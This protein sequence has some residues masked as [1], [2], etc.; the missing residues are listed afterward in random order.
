MGSAGGGGRTVRTAALGL[1]VLG[2]TALLRKQEERSW[3]LPDGT[4]SG[5]QYADLNRGASARPAGPVPAAP[6]VV[7]APDP[8][9]EPVAADL[10]TVEEYAPD[11]DGGVPDDEDAPSGSTATPPGGRKRRRKGKRRAA[12]A[13]R[14]NHV[15]ADATP[16]EIADLLDPPADPDDLLPED[17]IPLD[18]VEPQPRGRRSRARV[19]AARAYGMPFVRAPRVPPAR[20]A[21]RPARWRRPA[22]IAAVAA[23]VGA[24]AVLPWVVPQ[25]RDTLGASVPEQAIRTPSVADPKIEP[26]DGFVGPVGVQALN[27]PYAGVRLA[28]A[29]A[30]REVRVPRLHVSSDVLPISGR[31]GALVPPADAQELG[32]WKEGRVAGAR[33]G[34][35]VVTGHTVHTGGGA[36]DHLGELVPGDTVRVRTDHGW[37][38]YVVRRSTVY[39]TAALARNAEEILRRGGDGRLVLITCDDW[40]GHEYLSNAVVYAVPVLDEPFAGG[41]AASP[42]RGRVPDGGPE[43]PVTRRPGNTGGP[44]GVAP[45]GPRAD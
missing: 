25:V 38:R 9:P 27:G 35:A 24:C 33:H 36:F 5:D 23:L 44:L 18:W 28:A 1:L 12:R 14:S 2:T 20:A 19:A 11:P 21:E 37:I 8:Q 43:Q 16:E 3:P 13:A 7:P 26:A 15:F 29:G 31:S 34:S 40:N 41:P 30:P 17:R 42:E 32:W 22:R 4:W 45:S 10:E 39:S 6:S